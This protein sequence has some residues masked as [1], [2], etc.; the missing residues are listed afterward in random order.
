[1]VGEDFE[2]KRGTR[3]RKG[4]LRKMTALLDSA[5]FPGSQGGPLEHVIAGKAVA[6]KEADTEEYKTY[7][8]QLV[9]NAKEMARQFE[10]RGYKVISGGTD[11]HLML[12][13][14][15]TKFEDLTGRMAEDTLVRCHITI[16]KNTVPQ[17]TRSPFVTSGMRIGTPA[18][19]TRG[20]KEEQMA[21]IVSLIDRALNNHDDETIL[22]EVTKEVNAMMRQ[23]PLYSDRQKMATA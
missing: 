7:C 18:I 11:N 8:K 14:L 6:F 13:D 20:L 9:L 21:P 12:I 1:M 5:V 4:N 10:K 16:N 19:T 23:F 2:N 17:E 15:R 3:D 22:N